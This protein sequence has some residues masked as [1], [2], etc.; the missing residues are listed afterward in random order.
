M[1][2]A[3]PATATFP[4]VPVGHPFFAEVEWMVA[5]GLADGYDDGTFGATRPVSLQAA[6]AFL[7]GVAARRAAAGPGDPGT[8][9]AADEQATALEG[10]PIGASDVVRAL[11]D[12][13]R[14]VR[15]S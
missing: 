9:G 7:H 1:R 6:A 12:A 4:D 14:A 8:P 3:A 15:A 11:P 5:A 13:I 2:P 10:A